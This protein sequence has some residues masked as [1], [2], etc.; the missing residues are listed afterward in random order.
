M[1]FDESSKEIGKIKKVCKNQS[2]F[3]EFFYFSISR[4]KLKLELKKT[5]KNSKRFIFLNFRFQLELQNVF[6]FKLYAKT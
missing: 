1:N 3:S 2:S 4:L 5:Q 6:E